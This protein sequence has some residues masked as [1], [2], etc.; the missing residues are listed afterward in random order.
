MLLTTKTP[1][2]RHFRK[3]EDGHQQD[4]E[5]DGDDDADNSSNS[6]IHTWKSKE[7][8]QFLN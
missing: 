2:S 1:P 6:Q 3:D 7:N 5:E 8:L 4:H